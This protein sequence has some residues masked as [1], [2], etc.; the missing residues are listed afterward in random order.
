GFFALMATALVCL[1]VY[2][3]TAYDVS[4]RTSEI[5]VRMALGAQRRDIVR[6]VV[7]RTLRL[8]AVGLALGIAV[9]VA[10]GRVVQSSLFGVRSTDLPTFVVSASVL[11]AVGVSAAYWPA[12]RATRLSPI[13]SLKSS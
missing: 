10:L 11:V 13:A 2:G 7:G 1:G 9:A 12:R 8:F 6:S 4:R 3:R 5:A